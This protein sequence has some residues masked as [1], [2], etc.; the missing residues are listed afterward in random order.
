LCIRSV[1]LLQRKL[2]ELGLATISISNI[3]E[4]T[5]KVCVPR[6][7]FIQYPFGRILGDV[8]DRKGQRAVCADILAWFE[9]AEGPNAYRHLP[10]EWPQPPEH[11]KWHPDIPAPIGMLQ[12][13]GKL[14]QEV[15][16]R[17][18]RDSERD[19]LD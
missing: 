6:A 16:N 5:E 3:P 1:G 18:M 10:Y 13:Q 17:E 7:V 15:V 14:R 9:K 19:G 12:K 2:E 8:G 11:T 4:Q